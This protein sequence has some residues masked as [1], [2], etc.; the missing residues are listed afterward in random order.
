LTVT[1]KRLQEEIKLED[2]EVGLLNVRRKDITAG[3]VLAILLA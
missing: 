1:F 3:L 2:I